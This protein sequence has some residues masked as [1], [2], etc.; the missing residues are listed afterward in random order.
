MVEEFPVAGETTDRAVEQAVT[1]RKSV[2]DTM[3][4]AREKAIADLWRPLAS[5]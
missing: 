1:G 4:V 3:D 2:R 5:L